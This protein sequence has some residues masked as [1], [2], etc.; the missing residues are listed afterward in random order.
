M[1]INLTDVLSCEEKVVK[2]TVET[3]FQSFD[4]SLGSFPLTEEEPLNLTLTNLGG[5]KLL[6]EGEQKFVAKIPCDRCLTETE[7]PIEIFFSKE[8]D[9]KQSAEGRIDDLDETDFI[10]GYN[11]DTEKLVYGE[12]LLNWPMKTLCRDDCKGI[13][14]KCGKNLNEGDCGCDT[15]ELDPRMAVIAD[16]FKN[17]K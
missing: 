3:E 5:D 16:I 1:L 2:R 9:M 14:K 15:V 8:I 7:V 6:V 13:C 10:D 12:L 11:L 4:S 17:S